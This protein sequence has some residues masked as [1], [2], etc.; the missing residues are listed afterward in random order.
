MNIVEFNKT[1]G[2]KNATPA[3]K[4][5]G[6]FSVSCDVCALH[7]AKEQGAE[8]DVRV[9][10]YPPDE[11]IRVAE[12]WLLLIENDDLPHH[13]RYMILDDNGNLKNV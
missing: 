5:F 7:Q 10:G 3:V 8:P 2:T 9:N 1:R 12:G 6:E 4:T 13:A 11:I